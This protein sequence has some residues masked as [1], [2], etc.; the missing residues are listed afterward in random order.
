MGATHLLLEEDLAVAQRPRALDVPGP[1]AGTGA[2]VVQARAARQADLDRPA[3]GPALVDHRVL[4]LDGDHVPVGRPLRVWARDVPD[5]DRG[6][7]E[8]EVLGAGARLD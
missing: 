4:Q 2:Q 5:P 8:R 6:V 7:V 3:A 1:Q